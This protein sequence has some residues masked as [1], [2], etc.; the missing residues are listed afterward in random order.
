MNTMYLELILIFDNRVQQ[1][2]LSISQVI[3]HPCNFYIKKK[4]DGMCFIAGMTKFCS[5]GCCFAWGGWWWRRV[6]IYRCGGP[7]GWLWRRCCTPVRWS[8]CTT[9][10]IELFITI[11]FTLAT[12]LTTIP[13]LLLSLLP[14]N[15]ISL[16]F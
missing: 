15:Y 12:I 13:P 10:F 3:S 9:G 16:S 2:T 1:C 8:F 7:T 14:V 6:N 11:F 4:S 5:M